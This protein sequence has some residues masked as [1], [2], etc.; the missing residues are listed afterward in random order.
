[1]YTIKQEEFEYAKKQAELN[2]KPKVAEDKNNL[3]KTHNAKGFA[4]RKRKAEE[5]PASSST[6][7]FEKKEDNKKQKIRGRG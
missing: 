7:S 5:G 6:G 4:D 2:P 3:A 1:D